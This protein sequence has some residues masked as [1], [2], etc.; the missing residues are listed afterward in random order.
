M[1]NGGGVQM[2]DFDIIALSRMWG[3]TKRLK[4]KSF[5]LIVIL[6]II[7]VFSLL[8]NGYLLYN[9]FH[10]NWSPTW[11][12]CEHFYDFDKLKHYIQN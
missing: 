6:I 9:L 8:I 7:L 4:K 5:Y 10:C 2:W 1:A 3:K 11:A 12:N